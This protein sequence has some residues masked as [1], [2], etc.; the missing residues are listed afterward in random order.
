[1]N[2][3]MDV[4]IL[5]CGPGR[6]CAESTD[7]SMGG[8]CTLMK[9]DESGS[10]N[11]EQS[12]RF[13]QD[14]TI[15][16]DLQYACDYAYLIGYDC[17]CDLDPSTYSGTASCSAPIECSTYPSA[18]NVNSTDCRSDSYSVNILSPGMWETEL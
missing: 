9:R 8:I 1:M 5:S 10:G 3:V 12:N 14:E 13:L 17:L 18:C 6:Y 15:I 4:G 16:D 2:S 11:E 7:S